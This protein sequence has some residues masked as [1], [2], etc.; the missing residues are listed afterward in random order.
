VSDAPEAR[1]KE[2]GVS[3]SAQGPGYR[4]VATTISAASCGS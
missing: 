3:L 2:E 4:C 1:A